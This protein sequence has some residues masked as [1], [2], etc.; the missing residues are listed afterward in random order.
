[1]EAAV[2]GAVACG[3]AS[4]GL[5]RTKGEAM[6]TLL[7]G[8][9]N[10]SPRPAAPDRS[11]VLRPFREHDIDQLIAWLDDEALLFSWAGPAVRYPLDR[12]QV[13]T[14][15][16]GAIAES[17][18]LLP[19]AAVYPGGGIVGHVELTEI[20]AQRRELRL[21]RLIVGEPALRGRG[22]GRAITLRAC[23][24]A[25]ERLRVHRIWLSVPAENKAALACFA[26]SG[27]RREGV[28]RE[29]LPHKGRYWNCIVMSLLDRE[30]EKAKGRRT[31]AQRQPALA[32]A[33]R[34]RR[35]SIDQAYRAFPR[36][37]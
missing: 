12:S 26:R 22:F 37:F 9:L 14:Y 31:P 30:W 11:L 18:R 20:D 4:A 36:I 28:L 27:F 15:P 8:L 33:S 5:V 2:V 10:R 3:G 34:P 7:G 1:M 19:Y 17:P 32:Q 25:F 6:K 29:C 16:E 24:V 23:A 13:A 21:N 35:L